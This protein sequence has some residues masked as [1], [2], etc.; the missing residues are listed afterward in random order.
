MLE[1]DARRRILRGGHMEAYDD[2]WDVA[3]TYEF[4]MDWLEEWKA[5]AEVYPGL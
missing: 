2:M 4:L 5:T 3:S 1:G